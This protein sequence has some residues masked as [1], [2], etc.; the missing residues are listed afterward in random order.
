[1]SK[2]LTALLLKRKIDNIKSVKDRRQYLI[3]CLQKQGFIKEE[4]NT[5]PIQSI[6]HDTCKLCKSSSLLYSNN[7]RICQECGA[8]DTS[9]TFNPFKTYKQEINFSKGTFIEPGTT[10]VTIIKD[11]KEV[12]RDLSKM[13]TWAN[14][15]PEEL[16]ISNIDKLI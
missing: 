5:E 16:R 3:N 7:E 13:N 11:G 9:V 14:S 4:I 8:T 6:K 2:Q 15:D 10:F 12:K 1:M